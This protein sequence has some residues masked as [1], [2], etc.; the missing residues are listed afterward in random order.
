MKRFVCWKYDS[1][2][3]LT[4]ARDSRLRVASPLQLL[5]SSAASLASLTMRRDCLCPFE[6]LSIAAFAAESSFDRVKERRGC[7]FCKWIITN[8]NLRS[9]LYSQISLPMSWVW[10]ESRLAV[11]P[12]ILL[13]SR[14]FSIHWRWEEISLGAMALQWWRCRLAVLTLWCW[15]LHVNVMFSTRRKLAK[16]HVWIH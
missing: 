1:L 12:N 2:V 5:S 3:L 13:L 14:S 11:H 4:S 15:W 6:A 7:M 9:S 8:L 10:A 16:N